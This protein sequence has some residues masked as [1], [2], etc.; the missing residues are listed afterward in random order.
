MPGV[1]VRPKPPPALQGEFIAKWPDGSQSDFDIGMEI[2]APG[3]ACPGK[4]GY[5][6]DRIEVAARPRPDGRWHVI[7]VFRHA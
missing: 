5:V 3:D 4:P 2:I 7:G 6:L 1:S